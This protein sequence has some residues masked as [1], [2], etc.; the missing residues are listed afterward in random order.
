M[1]RCSM[2]RGPAGVPA[3]EWCRRGF[4]T[5]QTDRNIKLLA[6][7]TAAGSLTSATMVALG[8]MAAVPAGS[9]AQAGPISVAKLSVISSPSIGSGILGT[10]TLTQNGANEVDVDVS[11]IA[12]TDFINS[13]GPHTPFTFGLNVVPDR[14]AAVMAITGRS[15]FRSSVQRASAWRISSPTAR[16]TFFR[17]TYS[18]RPAERGPSLPI[19]LQCPTCRSPRRSHCWAAAWLPWASP[20]GAGRSVRCARP[21]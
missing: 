8:L 19:W 10:V 14:T 17:Q 13:G 5:V 18:A 3:R 20:G 1:P 6:L 16:A 11:L 4:D 9:T 21:E 2:K 12:H 15:I 7:I